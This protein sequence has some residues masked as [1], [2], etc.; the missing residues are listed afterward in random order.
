[1]R[2]GRVID[3]AI[4]YL[5]CSCVCSMFLFLFS[6]VHACRAGLWGV[7][8]VGQGRSEPKRTAGGVSINGVPW[9]ILFFFPHMHPNKSDVEPLLIW[10]LCQSWL[11]GWEL[12]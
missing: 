11:F 6:G 12:R 7:R 4:K 1:M 2:V 3:K 5:V 10:V 9:G 8:C